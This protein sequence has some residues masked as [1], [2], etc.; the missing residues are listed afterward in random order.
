MAVDDSFSLVE[1]DTVLDYLSTRDLCKEKAV[2]LVGNKTD[3][4]RSRVISTQGN[5]DAK[6]E[7]Y[8]RMFLVALDLAS[9][10]GVK[11]IETAPGKIDLLMLIMKR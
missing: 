11:Y 5:S 3:L 2:I 1:A 4:V 8:F 7:K 10:H 6:C 9:R